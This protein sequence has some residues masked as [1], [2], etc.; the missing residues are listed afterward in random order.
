MTV[1]YSNSYKPWKLNYTVGWILYDYQP[2]SRQRR[3]NNQGYQ[4]PGSLSDPRAGYPSQTHIQC[5]SGN[6]D[7][8]SLVLQSWII[9]QLCRLQGLVPGSGGM[10]QLLWTIIPQMSFSNFHDGN[11]SAGLKIPLNNYLSIKPNIQYSFPLSKDA[12]QE[13]MSQASARAYSIIAK[14]TSSMGGSFW[15][16][17]YS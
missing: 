7:W 6:R 12:A 15:T 5:L 14:T 13:I 1:S 11:I 16:W 3:W 2:T 17:Q 8:T 4:K 9:P 10:G